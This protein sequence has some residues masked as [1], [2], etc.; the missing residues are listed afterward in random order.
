MSEYKGYLTKFTKEE[1]DTARR[2]ADFNFLLF[3][4][5]LLGVETSCALA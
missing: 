1:P 5:T 3:L 4:A 2:F